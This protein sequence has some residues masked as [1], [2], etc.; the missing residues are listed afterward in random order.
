MGI[1]DRIIRLERKKGKPFFDDN[2]DGFITALIGDNIDKYIQFYNQKYGWDIVGILNDI[3]A[4]I[5]SDYNEE[6][7][8]IDFK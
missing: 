3:S 4:D 7:N 5:W 1:L 6:I 2:Q 8:N